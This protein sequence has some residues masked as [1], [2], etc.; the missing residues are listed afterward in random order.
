M[1]QKALGV[2]EAAVGIDPLV[3]KEFY[4]LSRRW[5]TYLGRTAYV[6]ILALAVWIIWINFTRQ[7]FLSYSD[8]SMMGRII[9]VG[10]SSV[11]FILI[12]LSA[13]FSGADLISRE[14]RSRT[15]GL[16]AI[17]P[18]SPWRIVYGK[19][20]SLMIS[21][22]VTALSGIPIL[23]M[24]IYLGGA[25]ARE[26]AAVSALTISMAMW[27]AAMA[28]LFS[29]FA[30]TAFVGAVAS[31]GVIVATLILPWFV[32]VTLFRG[33]EDEVLRA[34]FWIHP[35]YSLT[36]QFSGRLGLAGGGM[37]HNWMASSA[38]A[39]AVSIAC[40]WLAS[41]RVRRLY[42]AEPGPPLVRRLFEK[43]DRL[44]EAG[45]LGKRLWKE[46]TGVWERNPFLWK[47]LHSRVSGR[48]RYF[49]RIALAIYVVLAVLLA[50]SMDD[51][52]RSEILPGAYAILL[53][54]FCLGAVGAGS[55]AFTRE[56]EE[57]KWDLLLA[58]PI[59]AADVIWAKIA[60]AW[61][62]LAIFALTAVLAVIINAFTRNHD[63][64]DGL[65]LLLTTL[66]FAHFT[67]Q[68]GLF[69]SLIT[70]STRKARSLTLL[71][72]FS[73]LAIIPLMLLLM[74]IAGGGYGFG[75]F[76]EGFMKVT[77]PFPYIEALAHGGRGLDEALGYAVVQVILYG[78]ASTL[79]FAFTLSRLKDMAGRKPP[80]W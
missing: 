11:Q 46:R 21:L 10:F 80:M 53:I 5:Q 31:L 61:V 52:I 34:A 68:T 38:C 2:L 13:I 1:I 51:L 78:T 19:W 22:A 27:G 58:A 64:A 76:I 6:A 32:G 30:R 44:F 9:F 56:K 79:L 49:I 50:L 62:S 35:V 47:E 3:R 40:L 73:I 20:K 57:K 77:N 8:Y 43:L 54:L 24:G 33:S 16:L 17:T 71:V 60:G 42:R 23:A 69:F 15:L 65:P 26:L 75:Q 59:R 14:V 67:V 12:S 45:P 55:G 29:S 7:E 63:V 70:E 48:F 39:L 74:G 25:G 4:G 18:L 72:I 66:G 36:S 41:L 37:E 28:V